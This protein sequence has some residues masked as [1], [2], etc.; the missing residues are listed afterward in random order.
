MSRRLVR[1]DNVT[2]AG[3]E[4]M[5]GSSAV[6]S[7]LRRVIETVAA[8]DAP[9]LIAGETGWG[10]E[11]V[12]RAIHA[13]SGRRERPFVAQTCGALSETLLAAE[14][15]GSAR[16]AYT[17]ATGAR[18]G[19]FVAAHRGTLLLDEVGDMPLAMQAA[20]LRVLESGEVRPVGSIEA[21]K[22]D[23]RI[24]AASHFDLVDLVSKAASGTTSA[25]GLRSC[26]SRCLLCE[27][28]S[29]ICRSSASI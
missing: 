1:I 23:V 24:V 27:R 10:K 14:L 25:I 2:P 8:S 3:A 4:A 11:L 22:I 18:P 28:I 29:R 17:G 5:V 12:A 21:R 16:G 26:S 13:A 9:V 15:F 19:L 7:N 20:L 6:M